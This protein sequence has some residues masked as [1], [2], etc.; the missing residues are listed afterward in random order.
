[1]WCDLQ[2]SNIVPV[3]VLVLVR[4]LFRFDGY[5]FEVTL[6]EVVETLF[7]WLSEVVGGSCNSTFGPEAYRTLF[8]QPASQSSWA[9]WV[10]ACM[11]HFVIRPGAGI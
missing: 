8:V 4:F 2:T 11:M 1:M 7:M 3:L 5:I 10:G 6:W 9:R